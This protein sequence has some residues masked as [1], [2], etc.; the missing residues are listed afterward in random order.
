M[1]IEHVLRK[2]ISRLA[3][4]RVPDDLGEILVRK[5]SERAGDTRDILRDIT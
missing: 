1:L 4:F 3:T 5:S 2:T